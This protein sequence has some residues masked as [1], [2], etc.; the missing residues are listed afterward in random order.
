MKNRP[1]VFVDVNLGSIYSLVKDEN[2]KIWQEKIRSLREK[3]REIDIRFNTIAVWEKNG[4]P[5]CEYYGDEDVLGTP[6]VPKERKKIKTILAEFFIDVNERNLPFFKTLQKEN[7]ICFDNIQSCFEKLD[8]QM[9]DYHDALEE[10][11]IF[12][13]EQTTEPELEQKWEKEIEE[14]KENREQYVKYVRDEEIWEE[15]EDENFEVETEDFIETK[16]DFTKFITEEEIKTNKPAIKSYI[17]FNFQAMTKEGPYKHKASH[18]ADPE[19]PFD[20]FLQTLE[21][22]IQSKYMN[23]IRDTPEFRK[24]KPKGSHKISIESDKTSAIEIRKIGKSFVLSLILK[25]QYS[26]KYGTANEK[27]IFSDGKWVENPD[28]E[29]GESQKKDILLENGYKLMAWRRSLIDEIKFL[30]N[31]NFKNRECLNLLEAEFENE[32]NAKHFPALFDNFRKEFKGLTSYDIIEH[33]TNFTRFLKELDNAEKDLLVLVGDKNKI[34]NFIGELLQ[35]QKDLINEIDSGLKTDRWCAK[36]F[37]AHHKLIKDDVVRKLFQY[38][39]NGIEP[40]FTKDEIAATK[41]GRLS[42]IIEL[43]VAAG[44]IPNVLVPKSNKYEKTFEKAFF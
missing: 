19:D 42:K 9:E 7:F 25:E 36:F 29:Y 12:I 2:I 18:T 30:N 10:R 33:E 17:R 20:N 27:K 5:I 44:L 37:K 39:E 8:L 16:D 41:N 3:Y 11:A 22:N 6:V 24:L 32:K 34:K 43:G 1:V 4:K 40:N 14:Y 28:L 31:Y 21:G 35:Y 13:P 38:F 23:I 15:D 26:T